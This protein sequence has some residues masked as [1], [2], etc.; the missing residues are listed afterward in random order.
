MVLDVGCGT[1]DVARPLAQLVD[2]VDGVDFSSAM[3]AKGRVL[4]GG[5]NPKLNWIY[6]RVEDAALNPPYNLIT[7]G[8]SLHWMDWSV[9]MPRFRQML[10]PA[11]YSVIVGRSEL[12]SPWK[13]ALFELIP[14]F[15]TNKDYKSYNLIDELEKRHL[16]QPL[17]LK[18]TQPVVITQPLEDYIEALHSRN[19]FSRDRMDAEAAAT[20][21]AEFRKILLPWS[22]DGKVEYKIEGS[23]VWGKPL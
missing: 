14:K 9:V 8:E 7:A 18:V 13:T 17:G 21:D 19:G 16:F 1:G 20:F 3:L 4:P 23:V 5:D 22:K 12:P 6:G 11:G 15:T 2:R 10:T